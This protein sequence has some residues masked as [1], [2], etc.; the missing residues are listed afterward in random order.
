[1]AITRR[2]FLRRGAAAAAGVA[3]APGLRWLPGTNVSYAAGPT[4][5]IVVIVQLNGGND[6]LG[7]VYPLTGNQRSLYASYRPT[8]GL[9]DTQGALALSAWSGLA[10]DVLSIGTN[11]DGEDYALHPPMGALHAVYQAGKMAVCPGV[12]YPHFNHSHFRSEEIWY[13]GD[14]IGNGGQGWFGRYLDLAGFGST[15]VPGVMLSSQ[16]NPVF[17]PTGTSL[18]AFRRLDDLVFPANGE[19]QLKRDTIVSLYD[20][21]G[22]LNAADVPELVKIG[23]TGSATIQK[24]EDYY[25]DGDGLANAGPVEALLLNGSGNYRRNNSLVYPS[26]LNPEDNPG[27]DGLRLARDLRH[28]AATIRADVGASYFHVDRGGFDSHS[29]QEKGLYHSSLL[30]EISEAVAAFYEE[31]NQTVSL[32]GGYSGYRTGNLANEVV[33]V[34][35]SEFGRTMRQNAQGFNSAGTDHAASSVQLVVGGAVV[36]GQYGLHPQLDNPSNDDKNDLRMSTDIRD[37][38]GTI[39]NKWLGISASD[40]GPG[41][42]KIFADTPAPDVDGNT[43]TSFTP[44]GFLP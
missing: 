14:P 27:V 31:M 24:I 7:T 2:Q 32:P 19:V 18:F 12:H 34:T 30:A 28:V 43:Y 38:Y 1:M 4:N 23:E 20:E 11:A 13:T 17:T 10:S 16:L 37:L 41:A 35:L 29:N 5:K 44:M 6:G 3:L 25:K 42:G 22:G 36:G 8:L 15:E 9:P 33:I 26:P 21:T 40:I 39:L